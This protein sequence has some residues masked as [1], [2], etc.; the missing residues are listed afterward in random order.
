MDLFS[1]LSLMTYTTQVSPI[2]HRRIPK[3]QEPSPATFGCEV[4]GRTRTERCMKPPKQPCLLAILEQVEGIEPSSLP[5]QGSVIAVIQYLHFGGTDGCRTHY[6]KFAKLALSRLSY[7]PMKY[8]LL[9]GEDKNLWYPHCGSNTGPS[10][11]KT[12]AHPG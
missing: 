8:L 4:G 3:A 12:D 9:S 10:V 6:L 2:L 7:N 11:C 1:V 5:W